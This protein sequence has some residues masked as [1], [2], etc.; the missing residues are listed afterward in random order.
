MKYLSRIKLTFLTALVFGLML[1]TA[2]GSPKTFH[3]I[4]VTTKSQEAFD[5]FVIGQ[6]LLDQGKNVEAQKLFKRALDKD[7]NF[8]YAWLG[9]ANSATSAEEYEEGIDNAGLFVEKASK[10]EQLLHKIGKTFLNSDLESR[11]ELAESLTETY[12]ESPRAWLVYGNAKGAVNDQKEQRQAFK[13]AIELNKEFSPAYTQ[14]GFSYIFQQPKDFQKGESYML[15]ASKLNPWSDQVYINLGDAHRAIQKLERASDDYDKASLINSN[16]AVAFVK[17]GHV[18]SFLGKFADAKKA[19]EQGLEVSETV[20]R[21]YYANYKTFIGLHE[22][23]PSVTLAELDKVIA[24]IDKLNLADHQKDS[25][26]MFALTNQV[27]IAL[28]HKMVDKAKTILEKRETLMRKI[29]KNINDKDFARNQEADIAFWRGQLHARMGDFKTAQEFANKNSN[30]VKDTKS[31]RKMEQYH[32]LSGLI[33]LLSEKFGDAKD[34]YAKADQN[35]IY[36]KY[37]LALAMEYSGD[38]KSASKL[39]KEVAE[40]NFNSVEFALVRKDAMSRASI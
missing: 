27:T 19:Y 18:D 1:N 36:V 2:A 9:F 14:M 26:K 39:F 16:N 25:A 15:E 32:E 31:P 35:S 8:S 4:P 20:N 22:S 38:N 33:A 24:N 10:G 11:L 28:H 3:G 40:Y 17:K 21:P 12:P 7:P 6:A 34:S 29:S 23:K 30:L 5:Y 13:R 37:H